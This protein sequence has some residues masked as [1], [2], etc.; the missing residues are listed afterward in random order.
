MEGKEETRNTVD[1][2]LF[3]KLIEDFIGSRPSGTPQMGQSAVIGP[4]G[5]RDNGESNEN[6]SRRLDHQKYALF[7]GSMKP[8]QYPNG[9]EV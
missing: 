6:A 2:T 3:V 8:V 5:A 7:I 4:S 1:P 9:L